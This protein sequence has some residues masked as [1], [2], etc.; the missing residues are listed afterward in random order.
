MNKLLTAAE[1]KAVAVANDAYVN[2]SAFAK[3]EFHKAVLAETSFA[4]AHPWIWTG[5]VAGVCLG[6]GIWLGLAL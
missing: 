4:Q 1:Q 2:L 3:A 6:A 5:L